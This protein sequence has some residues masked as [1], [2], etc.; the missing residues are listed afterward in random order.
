MTNPYRDMCA[1]LAQEVEQLWSI[2]RD[3][4]N[5]PNAVASRARALLDQQEAQP[6]AAGEVAELVEWLRAGAPL[7][8]NESWRPRLTRAADL[9]QRQAEWKASALAVERKWD[10]NGIATMLG[11]QLGESQRACIQREVPRLLDR[12]R[13]LE[14]PQPVPVS[15]VGA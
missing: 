12:L 1:E 8:F 11:C 15:E 5:E 2:V 10:A 7:S 6:P 3:D 14:H 9:L 13:E 4:N